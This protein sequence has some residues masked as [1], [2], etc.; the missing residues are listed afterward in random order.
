MCLSQR[1][2]QGF[3]GPKRA[4]MLVSWSGLHWHPPALLRP[5]HPIAAARVPPFI[6]AVFES[7]KHKKQKTSREAE[8]A[9]VV[10]GIFPFSPLGAVPLLYIE[11]PCET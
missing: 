10:V 5:D 4:D 8:K 9:V 1:S 7:L 6:S 3:V 2:E 11:G